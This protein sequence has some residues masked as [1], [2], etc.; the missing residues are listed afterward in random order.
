MGGKLFGVIL[1]NV[2]IKT[3]DNYYYYAGYSTQYGYKK[4]VPRARKKAAE[5]PKVVAE[6]ASVNGLHLEVAEDITVAESEAALSEG[7]DDAVVP[8]PRV[9]YVQP[10]KDEDLF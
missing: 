6:V 2:N 1:N 9:T 4:R 5:E 7:I 3:D 10:P 8:A